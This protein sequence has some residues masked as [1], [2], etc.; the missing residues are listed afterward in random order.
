MQT[1]QG[2]FEEIMLKQYLTKNLFIAVMIALS[3]LPFSPKAAEVTKEQIKGLDEQVQ[4]IKRDVLELTTELSLLEEKLLFPSNTQVSLFVS[5]EGDKKFVLDAMQIKIDDK[6][7]A[8]HLYTFKELEALRLG[9]VQRIYT[10]NINTGD[11]LMTASFIGRSASG[12]Q[13]RGSADFAVIKA[14]GPK[15]VEIKII[16][17][18]SPDQTISFQDW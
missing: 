1:L 10:G 6:V 15:F 7:V 3:A 9:G 14:V 12:N 11:H 13:F 5:L 16:G 8:K 2:L 4:D 17:G 18:N